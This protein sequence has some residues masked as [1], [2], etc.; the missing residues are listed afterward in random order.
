MPSRTSR[1]LLKFSVALPQDVVSELDQ[2]AAG[3]HWSRTGAVAEMTRR[4]LMDWQLQQELDRMR[5]E[6]RIRPAEILCRQLSDDELEAELR[7]RRA[8]GREGAA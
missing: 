5:R 6:G 3:L 4:G 8:A 1:G 2:L 7:R